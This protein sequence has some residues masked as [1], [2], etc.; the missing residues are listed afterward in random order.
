MCCYN[1][2]KILL[3][4][5]NKCERERKSCN[6]PQVFTKNQNH[7]NTQNNVLIE[8][9]MTKGGGSGGIEEGIVSIWKG[10]IWLNQNLLLILYWTV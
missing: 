8:N 1:L 9:Y 5:T 2:K 4:V 10:N 6:I 3:L 7:T